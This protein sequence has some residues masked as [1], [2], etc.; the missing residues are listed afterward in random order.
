M[1]VVAP[2]LRIL[3]GQSV[4]ADT[5]LRGW[6]DDPQV[7][8]WLVPHNPVPPAFIRWMTRVKYLRTIATEATY[9]PLLL[10]E[11][12]R[13]DVVH[14]FSASYSSFLLAPLP[15]IAIARLLGKPVILNYHSGEAP[16]HLRRSALARWVLQRVDRCAVPSA[17]LRTVF[18]E[19]GLQAT[20][21]PNVVAR[22]RFPYRPRV[23]LRPRLLSTR[24]L[25][26]LYNVA[27][28]LRAFRRV[29]DVHPQAALTVV[30]AGSQ[31]PE[32]R[33]QAHAL[34]LRDVTFAGRVP[35]DAIASFYDSHDIYVQTPNID[36]MPVS[37]LEAFASGLAVVSTEAGGVPSIVTHGTHGLLAPIDD[38][39]AIAG[40]VLHLLAQ[41][42]YARSL[43]AHAHDTLHACS[44]D[45]VRNQ[46]LALYRGVLPHAA[47]MA[48][49]QA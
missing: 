40:H 20:V 44:W 30:G 35:P 7:D 24:N 4:Q 34:G 1:A 37:V 2:S 46:W 22:D 18:E 45:S 42:D 49:V 33:A 3:G 23:P 21:I 15:A 31:E 13:A 8:A 16:D 6:Q 36:N 5:L 25:E 14:V 28:T 19:H 12:R 43:A 32:L 10:T 26:P 29:Q 17:F 11:L 41:P 9:I 47:P 39:D 27:C 48:A 38:A